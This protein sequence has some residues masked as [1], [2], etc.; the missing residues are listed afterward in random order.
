MPAI[1]L[2]IW[3]MLLIGVCV[4][5]SVTQES[6]PTLITEGGSD[7]SEEPTQGGRLIGGDVGRSPIA[8]T[9]RTLTA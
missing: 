7:L 6:D 5:A 8:A 3:T 4:W 9:A 2:G 1:A